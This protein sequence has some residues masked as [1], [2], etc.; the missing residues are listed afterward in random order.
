M[1]RALVVAAALLVAVSASAAPPIPAS[2]WTPEAHLLLARAQVA[3][4]DWSTRDHDAIAWV[5]A[6]RWAM[7]PRR[8]F[9]A[10]IRQY[11]APMR[12]T[13]RTARQRWV[14]S[15]RLDGQQPQWWPR[16]ARWSRSRGEWSRVLG[17]ACEW[18][19]GN[20]PD[21]SGGSAWHWGGIGDPP[22]RGHPVLGLNTRNT[23]YGRRRAQG[24]SKK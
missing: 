19:A 14:R 2:Q 13:P 6:R 16:S 24:G 17:R 3:E 20:V 8:S 12:G 22:L 1:S 10:L 23:F 18:A 7:R 11:S 21:P 9:A 15:L 5:L 4:A